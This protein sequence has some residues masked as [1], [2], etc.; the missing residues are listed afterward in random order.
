M[1][2][3]LLQ[4][5]LIQWGVFNFDNGKYIELLKICVIGFFFN[6][7][8]KNAFI[9]T[10][11]NNFYHLLF[12]NNCHNNTNSYYTF[13]LYGG[14]IGL[15]NYNYSKNYNIQFSDKS[16]G[17]QN[18]FYCIYYTI[19]EKY[20]SDDIIICLNHSENNN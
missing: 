1:Y 10:N 7:F 15:T 14:N 4:L 17:N 12:I 9:S 3:L 11:Y 6:Q 20:V 2:F 19:I 13:E 5:Y 16:I 18:K 8:D